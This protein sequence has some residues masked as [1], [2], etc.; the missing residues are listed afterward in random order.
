MSGIRE[1]GAETAAPFSPFHLVTC[2]LNVVTLYVPT[3]KFRLGAVSSLNLG[4]DRHVPR[5]ASR[6]RHGFSTPQFRMDDALVHA[7]P[8]SRCKHGTRFSLIRTMP[9]CRPAE[10]ANNTIRLMRHNLITL[11]I[12]N[13][14]AEQNLPSHATRRTAFSYSRILLRGHMGE[15]LA[16]ITVWRNPCPLST[17]NLVLI[18]NEHSRFSGR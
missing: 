6:S 14:N 18:T 7:C 8:A 12:G 15:Q 11:T 16:L 9:P 5:H 3:V 10:S 2:P 4:V 13:N 17:Q 1:E